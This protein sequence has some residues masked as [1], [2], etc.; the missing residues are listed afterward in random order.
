M[1]T[2]K[3]K[4]KKKAKP[5]GERLKKEALKEIAGRLAGG[6]Q[7]HEVP[8]PKE[9]ANT[10]HRASA[11][12]KAPKGEGRKRVSALDAAA[13][14]LASAKD[15]MTSG[16]LIEAMAKRDLWKSPGGKTPAATLYAAMIR[17]IRAKGKEARFKKTDRGF[18]VLS[19]K[20][21]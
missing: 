2:T 20:G 19:K 15:P 16:D 1:S 18:F 5:S 10:P 13:Q 6:K 12:K 9:I 14:V 11:T 17:E 21:A 7:D 3:T 4:S 8:T